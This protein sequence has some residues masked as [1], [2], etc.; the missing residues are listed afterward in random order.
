MSRT[1]TGKLLCLITI[2]TLW[3]SGKVGAVETIADLVRATAS[4]NPD[5]TSPQDLLNDPSF[6]EIRRAKKINESLGGILRNADYSLLEKTIAVYAAQSPVVE[7]NEAMLRVVTD[8]YI[9]GKI[10]SSLVLTALCPGF[11]W[12]VH[13]SMTSARSLA[14]KALVDFM[15]RQ[16]KSKKLASNISKDDARLRRY[17]TLILDG[18]IEGSA[19][20]AIQQGLVSPP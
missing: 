20:A 6:Q 3:C 8:A 4:R 16:E 1:L 19:K 15:D 14:V 18:T 7:D 13:W 5:L 9:D 10:P 11:E 12:N 17:V 2:F